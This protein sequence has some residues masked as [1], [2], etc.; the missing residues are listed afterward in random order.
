MSFNPKELM[1]QHI[2]G[3]EAALKAAYDQG[4]QDGIQRIVAAATAPINEN[5]V[6]TVGDATPAAPATNSRQQRVVARRAP[7]G[8]VPT[9]VGRMLDEYPGKIIAE[10]EQMVGAYD[11]RVSDKSIGNEL[12]RHEG[13]KYRRD[14]NGG[15]FPMSGNKEAE[16]AATNEQSSA[17]DQSNQGDSL[18]NRLNQ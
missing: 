2:A 8:L 6:R 14:E 4:V 11:S 1:Q 12:R 9:I 7:R 16:D 17:S 18:W 13:K 15:W 10:Y 3:F 5:D